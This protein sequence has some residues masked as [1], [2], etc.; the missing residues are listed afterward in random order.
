MTSRRFP[1]C[2]SR[3]FW[4]GPSGRRDLIDQLFKSNEK[5]D[6]AFLDQIDLALVEFVPLADVSWTLR[7]SLVAERP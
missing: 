7:I 6:I 1:K 2:S 3:I 4:L 5:A